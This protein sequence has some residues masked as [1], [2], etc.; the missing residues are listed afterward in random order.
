MCGLSIGESLI[1]FT[2]AFDPTILGTLKL[3]MPKLAKFVKVLPVALNSG[4][5]QSLN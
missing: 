3:K 2:L 4:L 5:K 1:V